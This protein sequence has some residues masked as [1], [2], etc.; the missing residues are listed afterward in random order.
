MYQQHLLNRSLTMYLLFYL[1]IYYLASPALWIKTTWTRKL[2][3]ILSDYTKAD[4][5]CLNLYIV[6]G[7][8]NLMRDLFY[9]ISWM[10]AFHGSIQRSVSHPCFSEHQG[11]T[12]KALGGSGSRIKRKC[13]FKI[14]VPDFTFVV[15]LYTPAVKLRNLNNSHWESRAKSRNFFIGGKHEFWRLL[16][17][18]NF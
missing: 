14:F 16:S 3:W 10:D 17:K 1:F 13:Y 7:D 2:F 9:E 18:I 15:L 8:D 11:V 12:K 6:Y 5:T 4:R